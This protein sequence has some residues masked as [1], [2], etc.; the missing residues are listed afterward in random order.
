MKAAILARKSTDR[1][2]TSIERQIADA[3]LFAESRGWTIVEDCVFFVPEGISGAV[4]RRPEVDALLRA[5][6]AKPPRIDAV[7]MQTSDRLS[8]DMVS[9][10]TLVQALH[11]AGVRVFSYSTGDEYKFDT[12]LDKLMIAIRGFVGESEREAIVTR[13]RE[14]AFYRGRQGFVAG[15]RL[16]GYDNVAEQVGGKRFV[17]RRINEEQARWVRQMFQWYAEGWGLDTI[18]RELNRLGVP[19]PRASGARSHWVG[20]SV[21]PMLQNE[22]FRGT[23]R[24]GRKRRTVRDGRRVVVDADPDQLATVDVPELRIVDE[25]LWKR[26]QDRFASQ[27]KTGRRVGNTPTAVLVGNLRC[28]E[29]GGRVYVLGGRDKVYGCGTRHQSGVDSC[30]NAT[31]R[32]VSRVDAA[33]LAAVREALQLDT[34]VDDVVR[35]FFRAAGV[36]ESSNELNALRDRQKELQHEVGNL[37]TAIVS[38]R[39]PA[40]IGRLTTLLEEKEA[41]LSAVEKELQSRERGS[42]RITDEAR[43]IRQQATERLRHIDEV[44]QSDVA[45]GREVLRDLLDGPAEMTPIKINGERRLFIRGAI[46]AGALVNLESDPNG[47]RTRVAGMKTRCPGPD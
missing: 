42:S 10:V 18:A 14:A 40:V 20:G 11:E 24:F 8:R 7:I 21:R 9:Q 44:L 2:A 36:E 23:I 43:S 13:T 47:I 25:A 34:L 38:A 4:H 41:A 17:T 32:P 15:G 26:V 33:F 46:R 31:K 6:T 3:R 27:R 12:P 5:A 45:R 22:T 30:G 19:S 1:Q 16:F 39:S 28:S 35:E 29:C 37:T